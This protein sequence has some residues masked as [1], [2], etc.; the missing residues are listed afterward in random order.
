MPE[1]HV[2]H[3]QARRLARSFTGQTVRVDSPQGRFAAG[4]RLVS[5]RTVMGAEAFGKHLL[6]DFDNA[7]SIHVHLG[8]FGKWRMGRAPAPEPQGQLRLRMRTDQAYAELRGPTTCAVI[9]QRDRAALIERIGPD[10]IRRDADSER[11]WLRVSRS[12]T[13]I[14]ALLMDQ[15]VFAGVGNIYRAEVLF[16][17]SMAPTRT[18]RSVDREAFDLI[19]SDL[20]VLMRAGVRRAHI[21]TVRPEH[22]PEAMGRPARRDRH[23]GEVYVYRRAG[24]PCLVCGTDVVMSDLQ[25]RN[26]YWCPTCQ[27]G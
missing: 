21:D 18:G 1:G 19:W 5:G 27:E 15:S 25:G 2:V 3:H 23:G 11:A 8:L 26:L 13:S 12:S 17:Q 9:D 24:L 10:P 20:V 16:R 6:I 4:A 14:A 22:L 7:R